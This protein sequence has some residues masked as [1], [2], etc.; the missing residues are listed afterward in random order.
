MC[1]DTN[2]AMRDFIKRNVDVLPDSEGHSIVVTRYRRE[3]EA[4]KC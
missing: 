1:I 4:G 3:Q 2:M